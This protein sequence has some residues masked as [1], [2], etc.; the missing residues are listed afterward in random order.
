[1]S[2]KEENLTEII[3]SQSYIKAYQDLEFLKR[4]E[5]RGL[6]LQLELLKPEIIQYEQNI[7]STIVAFGSAR[8]PAPEDAEKELAEAKENI[9]KN[10]D[11]KAAILALKIAETKMV[12]AGYYKEAQEFGRI[13]SSVCQLGG[14]CEYVVCTGG[15][16]GIM[17]AANRGAYEIGAK[18]IGMNITLPH[19]Q[20]PNPYITPELCFSFH[21]FAIRKMHFLMR[22]KAL[23]AFPGGF[24]TMD[25]LFEALT[26]IQ[27]RKMKSIPIV[28]LG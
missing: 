22:A 8:T 20:Q 2:T 23:V 5:V 16:P 4:E 7:E 17:E 25:E 26:L 11:N 27:T 19:E 15:G 3:K 9:E 21:Y 13:V 18:T 6:R 12:H 10:P 14:R 28:L 1:M 24:G